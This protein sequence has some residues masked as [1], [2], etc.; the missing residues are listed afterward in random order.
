MSAPIVIRVRGSHAL[1][2]EQSEELM[3]AYRRD[4]E[5]RSREGRCD[6]YVVIDATSM[7]LISVK[8]KKGEG[9]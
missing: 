6:V 2:I 8:H 4:A 7:V 3:S 9:E 1:R 5:R